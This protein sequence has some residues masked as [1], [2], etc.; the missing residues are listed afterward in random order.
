MRRPKENVA[1]QLE[2]VA[3]STVRVKVKVK[4]IRVKELRKAQER[5][6]E[7]WKKVKVKN[8]NRQNWFIQNHSHLSI[9]PALQVTMTF[10]HQQEQSHSILENLRKALT[11]FI[12][13]KVTIAYIRMDSSS[14]TNKTGKV[15]PICIS[16]DSSSIHTAFRLHPHQHANLAKKVHQPV[17]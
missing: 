13:I 15:S 4:V 11:L 2:R 7:L 1:R 12:M 17:P 14:I 6:K 16:S 10:N 9:F 5:Q 8:S 3:E